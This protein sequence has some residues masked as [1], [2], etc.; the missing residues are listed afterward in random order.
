MNMNHMNHKQYLNRKQFIY[1]EDYRSKL[2]KL[3]YLLKICNKGCNEHRK[4]VMT[5]KYKLFDEGVFVAV[6]TGPY[7]GGQGAELR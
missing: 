7:L 2:L 5:K 4:R 3:F 1:D 6:F